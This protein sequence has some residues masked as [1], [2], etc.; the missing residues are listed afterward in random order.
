EVHGGDD[1]GDVLAVGAD[2]RVADALEPEEVVELH[3]P[4]LVGGR[5][6]QGEQDQAGT[7]EGQGA[8][9][10]GS[11]GER[12]AGR[13]EMVYLAGA[14]RSRGGRCGRMRGEAG[15]DQDEAL[16][17]PGGPRRRLP[18]ADLPLP[19]AGAAEEGRELDL[20]AAEPRPQPRAARGVLRQARAGPVDVGR[21]P[22]PVPGGD[23]GPGRGD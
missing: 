22:P 6:G 11:S 20:V 4:A 17:R 14:A 23:E 1:V 16:V 3:R 18:A 5:G 12:T 7:Q 13:E 15:D 10:G 19:A 9:Q 21:V 2:L 8:L